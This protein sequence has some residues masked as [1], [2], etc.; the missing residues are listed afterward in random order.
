MKKTLVN[1]AKILVSL[2]ILAF[3]AWRG[4]QILREDPDAFDELVRAPKNWWLMGLALVV[5]LAALLNSFARWFLLVRALG[6]PFSLREAVRLGFLG[7]LFNFTLSAAGGD[8]IKALAIARQQPGR[9][10][11]AAATVV[12]DRVIGMY[13]LFIVATVASLAMDYRALSVDDAAQIQ[14]VQGFCRMIQILTVVG[15][16]GFALVLVP[17][18]ATSPLWEVMQQIP[19]IGPALMSVLEAVRMYRRQ[20]LLLL[21]C[22]A[23]STIGHGLNGVVIFLLALALPGPDL[24]LAANFIV[25]PLS[26]VASAAPLP[27]GIGAFEATLAFLYQALSPPGVSPLQGIV[28]AVAYRAITLVTAFIGMLYYLAGRREVSEL[29]EEAAHDKGSPA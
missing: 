3:L 29:M 16:V 26:L 25:A 17:G 13:A 11:A 10:T 4:W 22:I 2:A 7:Y 18:F 14:T 12:V 21:V 8:L 9:R 6:L 20:P 24:S 23:M 19:K 1:A 15:T 27:G 28:I 5:S